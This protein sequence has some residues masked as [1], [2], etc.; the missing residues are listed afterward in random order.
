MT[1][2]ALIVVCGAPATGKSTLAR[3]LATDLR[4]PLLEKDIVK[5]SL[6]GVVVPVD[7]EASKRVGAASIR[8]VYDLA[9]RVLIAGIDV[10]VEANLNRTLAMRDLTR[11]A[12]V[13]SVL[14]VQC[15]T[16]PAL[17]MQRYRNRAWAGGRHGVHFDMDALPDLRT[18]LEM[19]V[20][21]LTP[22]GY[23]MIMVQTDNGYQPGYNDICEAIQRQRIGMHRRS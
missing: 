17:I 13:A 3:R 8:L 11:L 14:V 23:P 21:D 16:A 5:E 6:A 15:E 7:R 22:L 2:P 4:L 19:Q 20:H 18:A 9:Y 10:M 1:R 12:T